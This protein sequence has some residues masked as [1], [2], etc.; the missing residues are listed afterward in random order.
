MSTEVVR[1][2]IEGV[3]LASSALKPGAFHR[4]R[5][6]PD[7]RYVFSNA[8]SVT[9]HIIQGYDMGESVRHGERS[10]DN[11]E[12]GRLLARA[13]RESYRWNS[14]HV[15]PGIIVPLIIYS[16]ALG[17]SSVDSILEDIGKFKRSL[18]LIL[19]IRSW[20]EIKQF[21]DSLRAINRIDMYDHLS[22]TGYTQLAGIEGAITFNDI[23]SSLASKWTSFLVLDIHSYGLT[24]KV[25][26]LNQYFR[27]YEDS[28]LA[29]TRL[30]ID[31]IYS[32]LPEWAKNTIDKI[33]KEK[34]LGEK[35]G[36]KK[37]FELDARLRKSG[38]IFNNYAEELCVLTAIAVYEGFRP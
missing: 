18:E 37:L 19:G 28:E 29:I 6:D 1:S 15:Y 4:F 32:H 20:R 5:I 24:H 14:G 16:I 3:Y 35:E 31:T 9:S 23:F 7:S 12:I 34:Q 30:Y 11:I 8:V 38:Y 17:H 10:I 27:E 13:M 25:S 2:F 21:T 22:Q 33:L 36:I 26:R